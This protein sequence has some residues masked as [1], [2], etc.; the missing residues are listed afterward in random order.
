MT[1]PTELKAEITALPEPARRRF[2]C[3]CAAHVLHYYQKTQPLDGRLSKALSIARS[4]AA[5]KATEQ[6]LLDAFAQAEAARDVIKDEARSLRKAVWDAWRND[7]RQREPPRLSRD[8]EEDLPRDVEW[9]RRHDAKMKAAGWA[10]AWLIVTPK[11]RRRWIRLRAAWFA[12]ESA[13]WAAWLNTEAAQKKRKVPVA[14]ELVE[15]RYA[16]YAAHY[17]ARC[18]AE[19]AAQAVLKSVKYGGFFSYYGAAHRVPPTYVPLAYKYSQDMESARQAVI[20]EQEAWQ[21]RALERLLAEAP[22]PPDGKR[23]D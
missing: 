1:Q 12:A 15:A 20:A 4:F 6:G 18:P 7:P 8:E 19:A 23:R 9:W 11:T 2:A 10:A 13:M 22:P 3:A 5:G 16:I 17:A 21:R 14:A